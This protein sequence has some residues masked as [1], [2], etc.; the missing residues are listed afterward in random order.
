MYTKFE[1]ILKFLSFPPPPPLKKDKF[2]RAGGREKERL[3]GQGRIQY[4]L[5]V[6]QPRALYVR[7]KSGGWY[8]F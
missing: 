2:F 6:C 1:S 5:S 7:L 4:T 8:I 3:L